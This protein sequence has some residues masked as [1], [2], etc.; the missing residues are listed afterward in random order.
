M[1]EFLIRVVDKD[2]PSDPD[3]NRLRPRMGDVVTVQPDGWPWS[4]KERTETFWRIVRVPGLSVD[5]ATDWLDSLFDAKGDMVYRRARYANFSLLPSNI[6]SRFTGTR[7]AEFID[8]ANHSTLI[9]VRKLRS[10]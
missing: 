8:V 9:A 7:S 6:R 10:L 1:A 3:G 4:A 5:A 2:V